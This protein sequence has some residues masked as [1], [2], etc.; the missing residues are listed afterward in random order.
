MH[1]NS[2]TRVDRAASKDDTVEV[3]SP[4]LSLGGN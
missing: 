2:C 1:E 3:P 4:S